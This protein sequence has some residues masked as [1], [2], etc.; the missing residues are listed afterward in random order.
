MTD[1]HGWRP[2]ETARQVL[3]D[4]FYWSRGPCCAGCDWW[5]H[6]NSLVGECTR[7]APVSDAERWGMIG[8]VGASLATG[9]G[10]PMTRRD[11]HCGEFRDSFDWSS[12]PSAYQRQVGARLPPSP[13]GPYLAANHGTLADLPEDLKGEVDGG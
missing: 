2:I 11:H 9:A 6:H 12:L 3:L 10:H 13:L 7:S 8:F 4:Q 1:A 5:R